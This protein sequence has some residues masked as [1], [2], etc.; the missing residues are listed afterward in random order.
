MA[1]KENENSGA[2]EV[3]TSEANAGSVVEAQTVKV[4]VLRGFFDKFSANK[5]YGIGS[6]VEFDTERA[7]DVVSR[8]L[9]RYAEPETKD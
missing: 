3:S 5:W 9:A 7:A 2:L 6:Q 1:K 8:G 4:V